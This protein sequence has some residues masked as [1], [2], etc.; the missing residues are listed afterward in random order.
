MNIKRILY[1][2]EFTII[3]TELG[4]NKWQASVYD[5]EARC[6]H[7]AICDCGDYREALNEARAYIDDFLSQ[8]FI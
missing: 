2:G 7:G 6:D 5:N 8:E 1:R 4:K 3:L